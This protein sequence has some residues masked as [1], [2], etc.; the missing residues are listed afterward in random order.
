MSWNL[1]L[2]LKQLLPT[3]KRF[4]SFFFVMSMI[5]VALG[6]MVLVVV[7]SVMGG[8]GEQHRERAI[9]VTGHIDITAR[10]R[11]F[12]LSTSM[13]GELSEDPRIAAFGPYANGFVLAQLDTAWVGTLAYG[14]DPRTPDAYGL[15]RFL[16][17][18]AIDD[19][20]DDTVVL[21]RSLMWQLQA[22]IGDEIEIFTP[23]MIEGMQS[24][25]MILPRSLTVVGVYSVDWDP[26][27]IP[28]I[29]V[30]LRTM[31]DFY[32]LGPRIHGITVRLEDGAS[33]HTVAADWNQKLP[34]S[35]VA[36]T[37][38]VRWA[39]LLSVLAMEKVLIL[40]ILL[41]VVAVAIFSIAI[42]QLLNVVRRTREIG[43]LLAFGAD[44]RALWG[45]YCFQGLLIGVG[46][47]VLGSLVAVT[48]LSVR[49]PI[50][51]AIV[52]FTGSREMLT[53]YYFFLELPVHYTVADFTIIGSSAI[54][55]SVLAGLLPAW[56]ATK[57]RPA[58]AIRV[59][60]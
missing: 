1:Y 58:E 40:F 24:E 14:I 27:F 11:P 35:I 39:Q 53:K 36:Q 54:V 41:F 56:R 2:A 20:G 52:N 18:S 38:E 48:L 47:F 59:E 10:G 51:D 37:W 15:T 3:G 33:E 30:T 44:P 29:V 7:Q 12:L 28:G 50:I 25:E 17:Q 19:L 6:V 55:L 32:A 49:G 45:L 43:V 9:E 13:R 60:V 21:S 46:G 22:Q 57:L 8:F 34:L 5:G 16:S 31:Q 42:A 23:T 26:D 4:G